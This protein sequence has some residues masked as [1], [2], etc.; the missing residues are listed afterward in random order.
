MF[1]KKKV[2]VKADSVTSGTE[3]PLFSRTVCR[4]FRRLRSTPATIAGL[5][6]LHF[7]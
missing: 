6:G 1:C 2:S 5:G 4:Y 3:L 7:R